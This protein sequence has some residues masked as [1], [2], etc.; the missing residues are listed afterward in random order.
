MRQYFFKLTNMIQRPRLIWYKDLDWRCRNFL[1]QE[2]IPVGYPTPGYPIPWIPYHPLKDMGLVTRKG[3]G[4]RDTLHPPVNRM[5]DVYLWKHYL[6]AAILAVDKNQLRRSSY[7]PSYYSWSASNDNSTKVLMKSEFDL[8]WIHTLEIPHRKINSQLACYHNNSM[9]GI[10]SW[11]H[12]PTT[13][14]VPVTNERKCNWPDIVIC[15][16]TANDMY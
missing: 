8:L 4:T 3:P 9:N 11:N 10:K 1:I 12:P 14:A 15:P 6:S 2:S 7:C 16:S 5:T 13:G